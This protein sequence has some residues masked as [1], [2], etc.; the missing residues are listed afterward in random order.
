MGWRFSDRI[1]SLGRRIRRRRD[2]VFVLVGAT[3][4]D[5]VRMMGV[6]KRIERRFREEVYLMDGF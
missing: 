3:R 5:W 4:K 1:L 2:I 6:C